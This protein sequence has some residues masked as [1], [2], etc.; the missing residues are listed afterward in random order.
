V[1]PDDSG[2]TPTD[3]HGT[4]DAANALDEQ[5][6]GSLRVVAPVVGLIFLASA[7]IGMATPGVAL[8]SVVADAAIATAFLVAGLALVAWPLPGSLANPALLAGLVVLV[9]DALARGSVGESQLGWTLLGGVA[10]A[11]RPRWALAVAGLVLGSWLVAGIV[12]AWGWQIGT[13]GETADIATAAAI[14]GMVFLAR[15]GTVS[16]LVTARRTLHALA[17]ADPLTGLLNRRGIQDVAA[18]LLAR[19]PAGDLAIIFLDLDGFKAINDRFG[20]AEGDNAL[21]SVAGA[22]LETFRAA[23]AVGRI[24]GDEFLVVVAPGSD[25][26]AAAR[27]LRERLAACRDQDNRYLLSASIGIGHVAGSTIEAFW[28]AVAAADHRMYLD[29]QARR[30][31]DE[32]VVAPHGSLVPA[33]Q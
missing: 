9:V 25:V 22:L 26:A 7:A 8:A 12:G 20:H 18:R 10:I 30:L 16:G 15:H 19:S 14:A 29:K 28:D 21:V 5:L 3:L 1:T 23:D 17:L 13:T 24:G 11:V 33:L 32:P 4:R 31:D 2:M 27:R 6:A